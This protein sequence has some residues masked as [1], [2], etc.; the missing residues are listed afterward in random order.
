MS[1]LHLRVP[2]VP[3]WMVADSTREVLLA[4]CVGPLVCGAIAGALARW[5][6][7]EDDSGALAW[8]VILLLLTVFGACA[9]TLYAAY[10]FSEDLA[11][12]AVRRFEGLLHVVP[13]I[14]GSWTMLL[15][16]YTAAT[17]PNAWSLGLVVAPVLA[18]SLG[19]LALSRAEARPQVAYD[20]NDND[21][22]VR[23]ARRIGLVV[24]VV[25]GVLI[26]ALADG[27]FGACAGAYCGASVGLAGGAGVAEL[28]TLPRERWARRGDAFGSL[29][30]GVG[31][32]RA[33]PSGPS[34]WRRHSA[35]QPG[36]PHWSG[37]WSAAWWSGVESRPRPVA[38]SGGLRPGRPSRRPA[39]CS[40][41]ASQ[42]ASGVLRQPDPRY[43]LAPVTGA[44]G[45]GWALFVIAD[46]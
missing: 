28:V 13:A 2:P 34:A 20:E 8:A 45:C 35:R 44:V 33:R 22:W 4:V 43:V 15:A 12:F 16:G 21:V 41:W 24:G 18:G 6:L 19:S 42:P 46:F 36:W 9:P 32:P 10:H 29:A 26:G 30:F 39:S 38:P 14:V 25:V 7:L 23:R 3:R 17:G 40:A 37:S 11:R 27:W 31:A 5:A 1:D